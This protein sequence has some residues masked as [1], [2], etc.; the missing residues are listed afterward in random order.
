MIDVLR[1]SLSEAA[2]Q[3]EK[4]YKVREML[5]VLMLKIMFDRGAFKHLCFVG[6]TALR[7]LYGLRRYSEDLDFSLV[8][9]TPYSFSEMLKK[10]LSELRHYGFTA[11]ARANQKGVV[12]SG[13]V[14]F[15]DLLEQLGLSRLKEQKLAVKLEVDTNPHQGGKTLFMPVTKSFVF[16]VNTFDLPSLY[17]TK[18]HACFYRKFIK[19]RDF[20][21]LVW[22]LGKRIE[23]NYLLLNNAIQ[24]TKK[25]YRKIE[26]SN[27]KEFLAE[28][29]S[30]VDLSAA[31]KD[32]ERFLED[33]KELKLLD[34]KIIL[35]MVEGS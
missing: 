33:K 10:L 18:L 20:Y 35:G 24:Q 26:T 19:G 34:K 29:L 14:K 17:A 13:M 9:K 25:G 7:I 28:H 1:Q 31:K 11:E 30:Q 21:D 32:V 27:F 23:P 8:G 3:E 15:P 2:T 4:A 5:Q 12:Q 16:A 22:Y 6:G